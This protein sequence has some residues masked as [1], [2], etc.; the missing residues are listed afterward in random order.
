MNTFH[1]KQ[2]WEEIY[3]ENEMTEVSWYQSTPSVSMR[4]IAEVGV[5]YSGR[6]ID[7][8]GGDSF[9]VDSLLEAGYR[10]IAVV[11]ISQKALAKAQQRLGQLAEKVHWIEADVATFIPNALYDLWHDRAAFH[12][13][14][15][16]HEIAHYVKTVS[17]YIAPNGHL[18]L[19]TFS[20]NGPTMCSGIPISRYSKAQMCSLFSASFDTVD[21]FTLDHTTPFDTV[22]NFRFG[23]F[24]KK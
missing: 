10:D 6:V 3:E 4:I 15:E 7:V 5:P 17:E 21:C 20:E 24:R 16:E 18:V 13:L 23:I 9:L 11:D 2:H 22:Q 12:F 1:R 19:G 14:T 8:G